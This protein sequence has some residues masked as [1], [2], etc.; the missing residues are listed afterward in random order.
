MNMLL[1]NDEIIQ[2]IKDYAKPNWIWI[3]IWN[4]SQYEI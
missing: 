4:I 1:T 3:E 2:E